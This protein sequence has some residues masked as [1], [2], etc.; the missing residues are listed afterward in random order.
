M[1]IVFIDVDGPLIPGRA[2]ILKSE[3]AHRS[4]EPIGAEFLKS[5]CSR[6]EAKLVACSTWA[7]NKERFFKL[8]N[9]GDISES[10]FHK[11]WKVEYPHCDLTRQEAVKKWLDEHPGVEEYIIIDDAKHDDPNWI[12]VHPEIGITID[13]YREATK[14]L[15]NLDKF[16]VLI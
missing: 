12:Q 15:G 16:V 1:R 13:N 9:D 3:N 11:D 4:L 2:Y 5:I 6:C 7:S 8:F 14:R 10:W